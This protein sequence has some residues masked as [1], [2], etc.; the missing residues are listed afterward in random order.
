MPVIRE[1]IRTSALDDGRTLAL[2]L[3][4]ALPVAWFWYLWLLSGSP[5]LHPELLGTAA[6][7]WNF[8]D[9]AT[10]GNLFR[11]IFD[12]KAFDPNVNRVRP[13]NDVFE[14]LDA[15]ARPYLTRWI[16]PHASLTPSG[17]LAAVAAPI[18]LYAWLRRLTGRQVAALALCMIFL[19]SCGFLS[20]VIPYIRPA[21]KLNL[22]FLCVALYFAH[23]FSERG[24]NVDFAI[25]WLSL[26]C[27]FF[28]DELALA[29]FGIIGLLYWRALFDRKR[30]V[31]AA[32]FMMLPVVFL[33]ATKWGLPA[34]Y[35]AFSVHGAWD[36]LADPRKLQVFAFL[37]EPQF[38]AA[39]A[40]QTARSMLSTVGIAT[41]TA[42][43]QTIA[44]AVLVTAPVAHVWYWRLRTL[45]ELAQDGFLLATVVLVAVSLYATLLDWY[46]FP[47][48]VSYLGSFNY[49]YHSSI[50]VPVI[51]WIAYGWRSI[52]MALE[53][54]RAE[55]QIFVAVAFALSAMIISANFLLFERINRLAQN[56]H[57]YPF[58]NAI[59]SDALDRMR[60]S[61]RL[62][63]L[64]VIV[65]PDAG[66]AREVFE[67]D[68]RAVFGENWRDN[69]YFR[70][71]QMVSKNPIM[72]ESHL[73]HLLRAFFPFKPTTVRVTETANTR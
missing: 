51:G 67:E 54:R 22:V 23:R 64:E 21:K 41:H 70:V 20:V 17:L 32:M 34:I 42:V 31:V 72:T 44:L 28:A 48:E 12:W 61:P 39:A 9:T 62:A 13:L 14:V 65:A 40:V 36:A 10:F 52:S 53:G 59:L 73:A 37:L 30:K 43:T 3:L 8:P 46:P 27:S 16:G 33:A 15:V 60:V 24:K 56:I 68:L 38:Y 45:R 5:W 25:V 35:S 55:H 7:I 69:G 49:Y 47:F 66:R 19:A 18:A 58:T 6:Y 11:K 57:L 26:L 2:F 50:V 1:D 4:T 71:F 63:P 29:N